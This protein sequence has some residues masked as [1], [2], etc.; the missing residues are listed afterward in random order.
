MKFK[1]NLNKLSIFLLIIFFVVL[2]FLPYNIVFNSKSLCIHKNIIGF[3]CP[4][5]GMTRAVYCLIHL[6]FIEAFKFNYGVF[7][8]FPLILHDFFFNLFSFELNK[9][10]KKILYFLFLITI[11]INYIYKIIIFINS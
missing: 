11:S 8:L 2:Y 3:D 1:L 9:Y 10:I 4:G 6:N 7:L 5:C